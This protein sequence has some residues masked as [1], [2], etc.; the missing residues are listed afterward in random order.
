[1]LENLPMA[2]LIGGIICVIGQLIMDL[3]PFI[4]TPAHVLVGYVTTGAVISGLGL[5]DGLVKLAGAG[6]TVPL[7]GFGH[8]LAQGAIK[9]VKENGIIGAFSGGMEATSAGI[10]IAIILGYTIATIFDPKG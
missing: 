2:F 1:M 7:S 5:Y 3:T 10:V 4:I 6:A 9:G 8:A